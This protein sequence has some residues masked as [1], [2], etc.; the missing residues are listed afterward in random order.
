MA[1]TAGLPVEGFELSVLGMPSDS[2]SAMH[3]SSHVWAFLVAAERSL[4]LRGA[5]A[6]SAACKSGDRVVEQQWETGIRQS[7]TT[8]CNARDAQVFPGGSSDHFL[9][10]SRI[11]A[12][13]RA[14]SI[15]VA[16]NALSHVEE[17]NP[18]R[19]AQ[20]EACGSDSAMHG[21]RTLSHVAEA[22]RGIQ[23]RTR[24]RI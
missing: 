22:D 5:E 19:F 11:G 1:S 17:E 20:S 12:T 9:S 10:N 16:C 6:M 13:T 4:D 14:Q 8:A 3:A 21:L 15:A 7:T 24:R 2:V 23:Y 18:P